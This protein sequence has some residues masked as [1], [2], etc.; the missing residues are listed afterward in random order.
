MF[1]STAKKVKT[2]LS[3]NHEDFT[4]AFNA[5]RIQVTIIYT[6]EVNL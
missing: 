6:N 5:K 2:I 1:S 3:E 4:R